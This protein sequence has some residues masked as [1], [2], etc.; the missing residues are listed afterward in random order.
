MGSGAATPVNL[1]N[2]SIACLARL[3]SGFQDIRQRNE[4]ALRQ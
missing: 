2:F 3:H 4:I 1:V